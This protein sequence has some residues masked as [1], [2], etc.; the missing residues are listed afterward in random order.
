MDEWDQLL[1]SDGDHFTLPLVSFCLVAKEMTRQA[2][3]QTR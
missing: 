2:K 3:E 1:I